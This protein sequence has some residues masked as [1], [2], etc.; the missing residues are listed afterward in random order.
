MTES[1]ELIQNIP[2]GTGMIELIELIQNI[3]KKVNEI[4]RFPKKG[5]QNSRFHKTAAYVYIELID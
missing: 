4:K 5:Q 1:I 2:K 3:P